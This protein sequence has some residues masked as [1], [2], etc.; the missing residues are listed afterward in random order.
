MLTVYRRPAPSWPWTGPAF[1]PFPRLARPAFVPA[2]PAHNYGAARVERGTDS[3]TY[4]FD[5]PGTRTEDVEIERDGDVL[6]LRAERTDSGAQVRFERSFRLSERVAQDGVS[7][8]MADGVLSLTVSFTPKAEPVRIAI[9]ANPSPE[10]TVG[11][12]ATAE[13]AVSEQTAEVAAEPAAVTPD[14]GVDRAGA[15][16]TDAT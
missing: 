6:T 4:R 5:L 13:G 1:G 11:D 2:G 8:S 3:V 14:A 9:N 7:A 15:E 16:E 10:L 12:D